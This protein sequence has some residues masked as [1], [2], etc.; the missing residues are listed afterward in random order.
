MSIISDISEGWPNEVKAAGNC[1]CC[2]DPAELN[3]ET[4]KLGH[5]MKFFCCSRQEPLVVF[6][7]GAECYC[8]MYLPPIEL[9][10]PT[11]KEALEAWIQFKTELNSKRQANGLGI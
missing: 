4:N 6:K 11:V 9:Y 7:D 10:H 3:A 5:S 1:P 8:P 2:G